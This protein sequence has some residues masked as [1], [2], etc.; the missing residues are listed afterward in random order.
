MA[1]VKLEPGAGI[2]SLSGHIGNLVFRTTA[3]GQTYAQQAP[4]P[5]KRPGSAAQQQWRRGIF[6]SGVKY[7]NAQKRDPEG[8][9]YYVRFRRPGSFTSVY[10]L[11]L[12]DYSKPPQVLA[13]EAA[14]YQGQAGTLVRV[15]AHDPYGVAAVRVQVLDADGQVLEEGQAQ[16]IADE[17]W[18]YATTQTHLADAARQLRALAYDRPGN[19]SEALLCLK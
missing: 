7:S 6:K 11:V 9:A 19:A 4:A 18:A 13:L 8:I 2:A 14:G 17:W 12:A 3:D 5:V 1:R 16:L 10:S 15:R